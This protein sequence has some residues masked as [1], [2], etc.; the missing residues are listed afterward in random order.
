MARV[1]IEDCL[2]H[3]ENRFSLV[4]AAAKRTRMLLEGDKPLVHAPKNKPATVALR[5]IAQ[6]YIEI[7]EERKK[8]TRARR[9]GRRR[10][11]K[12]GRKHRR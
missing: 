7:V 11:L 12:G 8:P 3:I 10:P 2:V 9:R 1:T 6:G 4:H 5:E